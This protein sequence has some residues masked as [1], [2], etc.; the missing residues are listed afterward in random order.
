MWLLNS[1]LQEASDMFAES[2]RL[3]VLNGLTTNPA[4]LRMNRDWGEVLTELVLPA[5][6]L[7]EIE[8]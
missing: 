5:Y 3:G 7:C 8:C 2:A 1:V 4:V 6:A